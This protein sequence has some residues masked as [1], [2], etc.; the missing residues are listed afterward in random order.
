MNATHVR[1]RFLMTFAAMAAF[2][3]AGAAAA[4]P[5]SGMPAWLEAE[6]DAAYGPMT[7]LR[8][9]LHQAPELGNQEVKTQERILAILKDAGIE[10]VTGWKNSPTAVVGILNPEKGDTIALRADIDALPIK[11]NTGLAYASTAKG[12]YWGQKG[13]DVSHMCGHD[14]HMAMLLTAAQIMAK[15]RDEI[16]RRVVFVFQPAE[17]GDSIANPFTASNPTP[18]GAKALVLDGL[19]EKYDIKHYFGIHV[20][21]RLEAGKMLVAK[22]PAL[23]SAD[24]FEI[25][26]KGEQAHGAMPW[27]GVD[28]TLAAAQTVVSLQQ[29]VS[30][31]INLTEGMGVITVGKL[32]AGEAGNV[33]SGSASMMG[34]IRAN[35][36]DI[37]TKLLQRIPVVA[38]NTAKANGAEADVRLVEIYPVTWNDAALAESTVDALKKFGVDAALSTWNPGASEDFSFYAQTAPSVFMFLGVDKPGAKNAPNNHSDRFTIEDSALPAGV[39]AHIAAAMMPQKTEAKDQAKTK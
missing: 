29:I 14:A 10:T 34:T 15:H 11:E 25:N 27:T 22:G 4:A 5:V 1:A 2:A 38:E 36:P 16:N 21:A 17:E 3:A 19:T 12:T 26:I 6:V 35:H 39:R 30:R 28:A 31:N 7:E 23:N 13:V 33:M 32:T 8:H 9:A 20:M 18:S 24:A 37:R